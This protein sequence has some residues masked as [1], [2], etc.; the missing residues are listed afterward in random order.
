VISS[1]SSFRSVPDIADHIADHIAEHYSEI[2]YKG[3]RP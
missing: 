1:F 3:A 2:N